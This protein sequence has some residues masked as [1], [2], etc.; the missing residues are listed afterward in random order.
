MTRPSPPSALPP[1][2]GTLRRRR[3]VAE[4]ATTTTWEAWD[5]VTGERVLLRVA[6][7]DEALD[8]AFTRV[9]SL[10]L[11]VALSPRQDG[12]AGRAHLRTGAVACSL[13]DLLPID[14]P[15]G[16]VWTARLAL[17]I[18]NAL[19]VIHATGHAHGWVGPNSVVTTPRGWTL[20]WLGPVH[21]ATA[22]DDLRAV[23]ALVA[24]LDPLGPIGDLAS[25]FVEVP[26]PSAADAT[27]LLLHACASTLASEHHSLVRRARA[28]GAASGRARLR[29]L[30]GRLDALVPPPLAHGRVTVDEE[31]VALLVESDGALVRGARELLAVGSPGARFGVWGPDGLDPV[32]ARVLLRAWARHDAPAPEPELAALMRW[33]AAASRLRIDRM[34]LATQP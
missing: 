29:R 24:A 33:L 3:R 5:T 30:A 32:A 14:R 20:A 13:A 26:P 10:P 19:S 9:S 23:G 17:G 7:G 34:V 1:L 11:G 27:R 4:D 12:A 25:G 28:L 8:D 2:L 6:R 16:P 15:P 22:A 31:G 21:G 18:Y